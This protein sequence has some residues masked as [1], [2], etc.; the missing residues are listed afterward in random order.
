M[1]KFEA[2]ILVIL[3][4]VSVAFSL[5]TQPKVDAENG[6]DVTVTAP[7]AEVVQTVT[8]SSALYSTITIPEVSVPPSAT[9]GNGT[10]REVNKKQNE[11]IFS[12]PRNC[13][14]LGFQRDQC[15]QDSNET[16]C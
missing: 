7:F 2:C 15:H 16:A 11:F 6:T 12:I 10:T 3:V 4:L 14:F 13:D 1:R 5:E 8:E 9:V